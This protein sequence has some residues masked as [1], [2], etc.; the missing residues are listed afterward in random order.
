MAQGDW[1]ADEM[2][3]VTGGATRGMAALAFPPERHG[4]DGA[5]A[6]QQRL[7]AKLEEE[8]HLHLRVAP[9]GLAAARVEP[10]ERFAQTHPDVDA[11]LGVRHLAAR[12]D[13]ALGLDA[14]E[15]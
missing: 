6:A 12:I 13:E 8:V 7:G 15:D 1:R 14:A 4:G 3:R 5:E 10:C 9:A 2:P 11:L